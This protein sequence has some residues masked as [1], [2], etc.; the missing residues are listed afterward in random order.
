M[1]TRLLG[2]SA[3]ASLR[4]RGCSIRAS[5]RA[6]AGGA[7]ALAVG[8]QEVIGSHNVTCSEAEIGNHASIETGNVGWNAPDVLCY[9]ESTEDVQ[10]V[11]SEG[12][13][14]D[15]RVELRVLPGGEDSRADS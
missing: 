3:R 5:T 11:V 7:Q 9:A 12:F 14:P 8:L 13:S 4:H 1:L 10:R 2:C 15:Q 6:Y